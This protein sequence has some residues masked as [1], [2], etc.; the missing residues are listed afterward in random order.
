MADAAP[1]VTMTQSSE[2]QTF[3]AF[4]AMHLSDDLRLAVSCLQNELREELA[5][6]GVKWT[7]VDQIHLT[8]KFLGDVEAAAI[9][10]LTLALHRACAG[11]DLFH[12]RLEQLGCFPELRSPRIIWL[13][14][15][16]ET[17]RLRSLQT[18]IE[19]ETAPFTGHEDERSF[20]PH[21]TLARVR[22]VSPPERS[23]VA[24][25]LE[26]KQATALGDWTVR[27]VVLMKSVL[28]SAGPTYTPLAVIPL[29]AT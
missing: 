5:K 18:R 27:E 14:L 26:A 7:R 12:L 19:Q 16:G 3:R 25:V 17:E 11:H 29:A 1:M 6:A 10:E 8:L 15:G 28:S 4:V 23:H 22:H 13:G 24:Q 20:H 2:P 21:L 9:G